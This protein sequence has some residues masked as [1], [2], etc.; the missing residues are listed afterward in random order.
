MC[1]RS[2]S[3]KI[4]SVGIWCGS[5]PART[6]YPRPAQYVF[7]AIEPLDESNPRTLSP[8]PPMPRRGRSTAVGE[9][10][11]T[12]TATATDVAGNVAT[13]TRAGPDVC[14]AVA[15]VL[16]AARDRTGVVPRLSCDWPV[17]H[18]FAELVG[19]ADPARLSVPRLRALL[20]RAEP[21]S[22]HRP[23]VHVW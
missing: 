12:A 10:V 11:L 2:T 14:I 21:V 8:D 17:R 18:P 13:M 19:L 23:L 16:L 1:R 7:G 5:P 6:K 4:N 3:V 15:G 22:T 20:R 9:H